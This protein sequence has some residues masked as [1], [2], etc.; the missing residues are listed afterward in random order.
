[1][2]LPETHIV[3]GIPYIIT[4]LLGHGKGGYSYLAHRQDDPA[5]QV[6]LKQIHH[7]PCSYYS[8]GDKIQAEIHDYERLKS[9]G[10]RIPAMIDVDVDAE[11]LVK[12]YV[13]GPTILDLVLADRMRPEYVEQVRQM[14]AILKDAGLNID[15]FPTNFIV[16]DDLIYY[17][18]FEC[19]DYMD[20]WNF[21]NW[22]VNYWSK[23][24]ELMDW[25]KEH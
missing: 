15:Y 11:R 1:M 24:P 2:E 8:F 18:D 19:N 17:I 20:E 16:H 5:T 6:T 3:N 9:T 14:A 12:E 25:V 21:D 23:T 13:D 22:G 7:E 4:K 10:I